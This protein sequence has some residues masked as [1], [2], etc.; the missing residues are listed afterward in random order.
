MQLPPDRLAR[1]ADHDVRR[2]VVADE[3]IGQVG[4]RAVVGEV[5]RVGDRAA[6]RRGD[7]RRELLELVCRRYDGLDVP[8]VMREVLSDIESGKFADEWDAERDAGYPNLERLRAEK[9]NPDFVA[10]EEDLRARLG[11]RAKPPAG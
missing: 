1:V 5:G 3:R 9:L 8:G 11:E 7:R 2:P 4:D 10:F 6:A